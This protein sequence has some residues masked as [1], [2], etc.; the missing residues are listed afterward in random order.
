[1]I[2]ERV[3][4]RVLGAV[5]F[6]DAAS[7]TPIARRMQLDAADL[8]FTQGARHLAIIARAKGFD[9]YVERFEPPL[10][11]IAATSFVATVHD[12][13]GQYLPRRFS[14]VLPRTPATAAPLAATSVFRPLEVALLPAATAPIATSWAEARITVRDVAGNA[15][16]PNVLVRALGPAALPVP[17]RQFGVGMT[18]ARGEALVAMPSVPLFRTSNGGGAVMTAEIPIRIELVPLPHLD[19]AGE[20]EV[21]DWTEHASDPAIAANRFDVSL[22]ASRKLAFDVAVTIPP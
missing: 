13:V 21:V 9:A 20:L 17:E 16:R 19:A 1:V 10:P 15:L 8:H 6:M 7:R 5:R 4:Q 12:P 18:D 11:A 14:I 3:E 22:T 2:V